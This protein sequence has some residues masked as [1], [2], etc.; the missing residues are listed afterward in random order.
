MTED[1]N[2][3]E[4]SSLFAGRF[5]ARNTLWNL[6]GQG[7]PMIA[8]L[9]CIPRIIHI[10]GVERFGVLTLAWMV[11]GYFSLFDLGLG[12]AL[13]KLVAEKL[14]V[15]NHSE[16]PSLV[17]TALGLM[18]LLG[19]VGT[20]ILWFLTPHLVTSVFKIPLAL[21]PET[22]LAFYLLDV[23]IPIVISSASLR[24]VLEA[25]QRFALLTYIRVPMGIFSFVGP[26]IAVSFS[27]SLVIVV[28][29][30]VVGR[31]VGWSINLL[32]CLHTMPALR[33]D[34]R[35]EWKAVGPLLSFG[36]WMTVSNVVSP[37]MVYLDRFLI[38]ALISM[39]AVA[40]YA[41]PFEI[42]TKFLVIAWAVSGVLFPAFS[43]SFAHD[44]QRTVWLFEK[45][46]I[47]T[48]GILFVIS[49]L[50]IGFS[51]EILGIWLGR[52]FAQHSALVLQLLT[53]GV[54]IYSL[55]HVPFA[56]I[57]GAGRPDLTAKLHFAEL[58]CYLF[59]AWWLVSR[60]G[61]KGA[62]IAW[63]LRVCVDA[64][65]LF[66]LAQHVVPGCASFNKK[67]AT[68]SLM[69]FIS[70]G[71]IALK[72]GLLAKSALIFFMLIVFSVALWLL[73][74]TPEERRTLRTVSKPVSV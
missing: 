60:Y 11:T 36:G 58:P 19:A 64:F 61:V 13:T 8:A 54:F 6:F 40:Y 59:A 66:W 4:I 27:K 10:L 32:V 67:L 56:L 71:L 16:I 2:N 42:V 73:I 38:G 15:G 53:S 45:G 50:T 37:L 74:L 52:D 17:W 23:S 31:L 57:Q 33:S 12:R 72:A 1:T 30:L 43:S 47:S 24:G 22:K 34:F 49:I 44:R 25:Q 70:F 28:A 62:A 9:F 20:L 41:T 39:S 65:L 5:L 7:A 63:V 46:L 55:A 68:G 18:F 51:H 21:Q 3:V 35:L 48:F 29:V 26:L 14:G 69:A